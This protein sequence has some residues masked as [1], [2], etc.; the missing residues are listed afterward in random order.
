M[1]IEYC[2]VAK[3]AVDFVVFLELTPKTKFESAAPKCAKG[4]PCPYGMPK[5][6]P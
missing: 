6:I 4:S 1:P 2:S 3:A 5:G